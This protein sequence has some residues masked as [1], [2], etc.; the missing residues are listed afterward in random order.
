M[1]TG[2]EV[3]RSSAL[4]PHRIRI[5]LNEISALRG[6]VDECYETVNDG[7][8]QAPPHVKELLITCFEQGKEVEAFIERAAES[9]QQ[10]SST[11]LSRLKM[12][13]FILSSQGKQ[14]DS[15]VAVFRDKVVILRDACSEVR[16]RSQ[17][18]ELSAGMAR[19]SGE[20]RFHFEQRRDYEDMEQLRH[21]QEQQR[22]EKEQQRYDKEQQ[23]H[24]REQR[25]REAQDPAFSA[26]VGPSAAEGSNVPSALAEHGDQGGSQDG[27]HLQLEVA[28]RHN[29][30]TGLNSLAVDDFI[31]NGVVR[32][33]N[34]DPETT[35]TVL[36]EDPTKE[37]GDRFRPVPAA[38]VPYYPARIKMDTGSTDDFVTLNYLTRAGFNIESL[39]PIP[40]DE[41]DE[42]EGLNR[43]MYKPRFKVNLKYYRQ[44]ESQMNDI[45]FFVVD[46]GPFDLLL[47]S[48]RFAEEAERHL[49]PYSLPMV[50][51]KRKT[52]E[53]IGKEIEKE[54][55]KLEEAKKQEQRDFE[56]A[57]ARRVP[58]GRVST[59]NTVASNSMP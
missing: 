45:T 59:I 9:R 54:K 42:I 13:S 32:V 15:S 24:E 26:P 12:M 36:V 30:R 35:A 57:R 34:S 47:S 6:V 44:G 38:V 39:K 16:L 25:M 23:R 7:P 46:Q 33:E 31:L 2:T 14:L 29:F 22:Y 50:R 21:E 52:R 48:R 56:I 58:V 53:E 41:Q 28:Q 43:V 11:M 8:V 5:L 10:L 4:F 20:S 55:K 18:V 51:R 37:G 40:E 17:L 49:Y 3:Y 27:D 19:I 1:K